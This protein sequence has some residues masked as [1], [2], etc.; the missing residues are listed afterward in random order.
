MLCLP[1]PKIP[2]PK[3]FAFLIAFALGLH[4]KI[5]VLQ[6]I[7]MFF[8][9]LPSFLHDQFHFI[10]TKPKPTL[11]L[12]VTQCGSM[13]SLSILL[14]P[15]LSHS[16]FIS[17]LFKLPFCLS[18]SNLLHDSLSCF[19]FISNIHLNFFLSLHITLSFSFLLSPYSV[20][21]L[22]WLNFLPFTPSMG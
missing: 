7:F 14:P 3:L 1:L 2:H 17:S 18:F 6:H 4:P 10:H 8:I 20:F 11:M 21:G 15:S 12:I 19:I 5:L 9:H 13:F 16:H 22:A